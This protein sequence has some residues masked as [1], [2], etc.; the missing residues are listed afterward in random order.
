MKVN[1]ATLN[2]MPRPLRPTR[3]LVGALLVVVLVG[4]GVRAAVL[5]L[6]PKPAYLAGLAAVQAE[7]AANIIDYDRW[8]VVDQR[9]VNRLQALQNASGSLV[10]PDAVR[11]SG[12]QRLEPQILE[13]PGLAVVDAGVW[14]AFGT[15]TYQ[16]VRWLQV[17]LDAMM[18][19]L[20]F[21]IGRALT[22]SV[23]V[24]LVAAAAYAVWPGAAVLAKTPSLDT[25]TTFFAI[26]ALSLF[27]W[28]RASDQRYLRLCAFGILVGLGVYFRPFL[29]VAAPLLPLVGLE[30]AWRRRLV[31]A[32]VPTLVALAVVAPWTVR[33][34]Y[35]FH[36]FI[37]TRSGLGQ[38]LWEGLGQAHNDFGAANNDGATVRLV[39]RARPDLREGTPAFDDFLL[40]R[41]LRAIRAEPSFYAK[42]VARRL[43][44]LL[45]CVV[46]LLWRRRWPRERLILVGTAFA[47]VLPYA[48]LRMENR[49]WLPAS[50]A[51]FLLGALV[52]AAGLRTR[53]ALPASAASDA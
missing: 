53:A 11:P 19:L 9:T 22:Q 18:I 3:T 35:A 6:N 27:V 36:R 8:F 15:K 29:I 5:L 38:A 48:F 13:M 33:N 52:V 37:P 7:M 41:S 28:A 24:G 40:H 49:F 34:A 2:R 4:L 26:G 45:P 31:E 14:K 50:F 20:I 12:H 42:L 21:W 47:L 46:A 51:Y 43:L 44:Y 32:L 1:E 39:R 30:S 17:V 23:S 16:P 10:S 25:W